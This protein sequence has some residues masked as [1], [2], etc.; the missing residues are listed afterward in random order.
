MTLRAFLPFLASI[1]NIAASVL[2]FHLMNEAPVEDR[3]IGR[4]TM[5]SGITAA[6]RYHSYLYS[7]LR[8]YLGP[9]V[10]EIGSG[11]GQY[12]AMLL[13]DDR[14]VLA[15]DIERKFIAE[16]QKR[17]PGRDPSSLSGAYIDLN[18]EE[19]V[20]Q[21]LSW[22]P[23]SVLCLNVLEHIGEDCRALS[24][25]RSHAQ[26]PLTAVFL[27]PAHQLL[28]GFMDEEAGHFRRY[29]RRTLSR[30][31]KDAGWDV[32]K[33]FYLNPVGAVGWFVRNKVFPPASRS[34]DDPKV[35]NDIEIF[36]RYLL[37]VT[38]AVEPATRAIFGQSVVVVAKTEPRTHLS[39][40]RG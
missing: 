8:R 6:T 26:A 18:S 15:S 29:T 9:R 23:D 40:V 33:S 35:N 28:F 12:T 17:F 37:P 14:A 21:C 34:L 27:T 31:F 24:W 19:T 32:Q 30:A 38:K 36:D 1:D 11:Y 13:D 16:I 4:A 3:P 2:D 10:W 20:A 5:S 39:V 7:S 22:R 25:I